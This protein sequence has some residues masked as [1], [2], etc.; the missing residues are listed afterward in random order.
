[1]AEIKSDGVYTIKGQEAD[2]RFQ[3]LKGHQVP[4]DVEYVRV[5]DIEQAGAKADTAA[6][7]KAAAKPENKAAK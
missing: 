1:M 3:F 7:N 5:G 2:V 4:D 6:E